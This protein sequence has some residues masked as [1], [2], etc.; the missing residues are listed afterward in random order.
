MAEICFPALNL[1][2]KWLR[3]LTSNLSC[4]NYLNFIPNFKFTFHSRVDTNVQL[5]SVLKQYTFLSDLIE[6][7]KTP[8]GAATIISNF[9]RLRDI[10]VPSLS[11]HVATNFSRVKDLT[12]PL[13]PLVEKFTKESDIRKLPITLDSALMNPKGNL[14]VGCT[15]SVVGVGCIESG[16]MFH[17]CPG[18]TS[19]MDP[20][21]AV[22]LLYLQYL[23][24]L[25]GPMWKKIRKN[26]YGYNVIPRPNEGLIVFT[27]YR[28]TNIYEAFKDAKTIVEAQVEDSSE[29]DQTLLESAKSS[30]IFE[31]IEREKT[32]GDLV[33]QA[34][35]NS[36]KGIPKDYN[37]YLVDQ[38]ATITIE[39]LRRIGTK[40]FKRMFDPTQAKVVIVCHPDKVEAIR[41]QFEEFG[42]NLQESSSLEE[43]I[44]SKCS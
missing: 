37:K 27:L 21:M 9:N 29:F 24:Q 43:S 25:E 11:L 44:L 38:V 42:H 13:K 32:V 35:L 31:I 18:I 8:D 39:D 5:N 1:T 41:K 20:D 30:L 4:L 7:L 36:F 34:I 19:F 16:F 10:L 22:I 12:G 3:V 2:S 40:Y 17:T 33:S 28:A 6:T 15:G 26:S 14:P 23:S